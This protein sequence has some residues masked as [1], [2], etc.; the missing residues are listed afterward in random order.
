MQ[1]YADFLPKE[2]YFPDQPSLA[3]DQVSDRGVKDALAVY[4]STLG[5]MGIKPDVIPSTTWDPGMIVVEALRHSGLDATA[6]QL[7]DD[8]ANLRGFAGVTGRFDFK[9]VP[10]RGLGPTSVI[11]TRW[12][13]QR[14]TWVG[15]SKPGG[16]PLR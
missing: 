11:I 14:G 15:A 5:G 13:A 16:E 6:A 4:F 9:A 10:Q 1:Q 7:R 8:V 2:L 3:P 12:D